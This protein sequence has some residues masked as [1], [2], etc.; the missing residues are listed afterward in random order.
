MLLIDRHRRFLSSLL[1]SPLLFSSVRHPKRDMRVDWE[2]VAL[3]LKSM[4]ITDISSCSERGSYIRGQRETTIDAIFRAN[5]LRLEFHHQSFVSVFICSFP[6]AERRRKC[7]IFSSLSLS[8]SSRF[9]S[10]F[11]YIDSRLFYRHSRRIIDDIYTR[12][13]HLDQ[14]DRNCFAFQPKD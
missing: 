8:L 3:A 6:N 12:Y 9:F 10:H 1:S 14:I 4:Y 11:V 5:T 7:A 13:N 2:S